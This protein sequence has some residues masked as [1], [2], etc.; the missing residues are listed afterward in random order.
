NFPRYNIDMALVRVYEHDQP[1][2]QENSFK[3][4]TAG[5]KE[6]SLVFVTGN[7]GGTSRLDTV[8]HR[9][10]L[11]DASIPNVIRVLE[12]QEALLKKYM[13]MGEEQTRQAENELNGVQNELKVYRGRLQGLKDSTLM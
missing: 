6:G 4:S 8:A 2:H 13:A 3:W 10:D 5:A 11:L 1:V 7:P 9:E 12:R